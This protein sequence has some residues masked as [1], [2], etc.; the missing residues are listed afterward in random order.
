MLPR[1]SLPS[2]PDILITMREATVAETLDFAG[3]SV[4]HEEEVTTLFLNTVQDKASFVDCRTWTAEDRRYALYWYYS[5]TPGDKDGPLSY[6]CQHCGELHHFLQDYRKLDETYKPIQGLPE[7]EL[8]WEGEKVIV[9]PVDGYGMEELEEM[10]LVLDEIGDENGGE[11]Q[12]QAALMRFTRFELAVSFADPGNWANRIADKLKSKKDLEA[13][14]K[15]KAAELRA[16]KRKKL[17]SMSYGKFEQFAGLVVEKLLEMEHGLNS[18][19]EGGK[20]FLITPPHQCPKK[21][22][23]KEATTRIR[24]TFRNSDYIPRLH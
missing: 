12:R 18:I 2:R 9:R 20:V 15:A 1:F 22:D 10:Q 3:V 23:D 17:M 24:V 11:Y 13:E 7:R 14:G 16:A 19:Y 4:G 5:N 21:K 8:E 6:E